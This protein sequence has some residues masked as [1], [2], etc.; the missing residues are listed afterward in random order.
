MYADV[1]DVVVEEDTSSRLRASRRMRFAGESN[2][3][4]EIGIVEDEVALVEVRVRE[5]RRVWNFRLVVAS[6]SG[7]CDVVFVSVD[8]AGGGGGGG[9]DGAA[10]ICVGSSM[11]VYD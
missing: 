11:L 9:R 7:R 6:A 8:E 1:V 2:V 10:G 3:L 5:S 4:P